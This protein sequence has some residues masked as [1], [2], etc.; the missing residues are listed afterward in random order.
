LVKERGQEAAE[1]PGVVELIVERL[2]AAT[3]EVVTT[4]GQEAFH[5]ISERDGVS[6][7]RRETGVAAM[8]SCLDAGDDVVD[9][10]PGSGRVVNVLEAPDRG[11]AVLIDAG[12][13]G[14]LEGGNA[15]PPTP[16]RGRVGDPGRKVA[17]LVR[18]CTSHSG[19][20]HRPRRGGVRLVVP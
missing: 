7:P 15:A 9:P 11:A 14:L 18:P 12:D 3:G 17:L 1:G 19:G 10:A 20:A 13:G 8:W 4:K 5:P 6:R 2:A 16:P